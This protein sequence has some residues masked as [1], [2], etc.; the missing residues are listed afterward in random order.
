MGAGTA[1]TDADPSHY[2]GV[3]AGIDI[4][5]ATNGIDADLRPGPFIPAGSAV[6]WTYVVT[7]TGNA[8]LGAITVTDS[9]TGVVP[10]FVGGDANNNSLLDLTETWTYQATGT[11]ALGQ[12]ENLGSVVG[13]GPTGPVQDSDAS[14]YFGEQLGIN[15]IKT[16]NGDDANV[17][18]GP[19][20]PVGG[21]VI[22]RYTFT[23]TG[24]VP[25]Q[26]VVTD[27]QPDVTVACPRLLFIVPGRP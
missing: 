3:A 20:V 5:K 21:N 13:T 6:T 22:W 9:M 18:T 10:T 19:L 25:L 16:T 27:D 23:N 26:F 14:H 24:N 17:P 1:V 11:A 15:L 2:F 12:Y 4:E 7:N 8:P